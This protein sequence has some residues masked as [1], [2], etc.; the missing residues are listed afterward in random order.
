MSDPSETWTCTD[1]TLM[2]RINGV[3]RKD[4]NVWGCVNYGQREDWTCA[5]C[6]FAYFQ[7]VKMCHHEYCPHYHQRVEAPAERETA[8]HVRCTFIGRRFYKHSADC[9]DPSATEVPVDFFGPPFGPPRQPAE[10]TIEQRYAMALERCERLE[11]KV[12]EKDE[13]I[14]RMVEKAADESLD[15]YREI[16]ARCAAAENESDRLRAQV[17]AGEALAEAAGRVCSAG[18]DAFEYD[19]SDEPE[20]MK[21]VEAMRE[22]LRAVKAHN[23]GE[24]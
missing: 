5:G 8:T 18:F 19:Y 7:R 21:A 24:G 15:G 12:A 9:P 22:A 20:M 1:C 4:C 3:I 6:D 10:I 2:M 16:G 13:F 23:E 11:E 14:R 17:A